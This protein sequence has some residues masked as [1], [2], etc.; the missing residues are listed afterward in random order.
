MYR[1]SAS[2]TYRA[3]CCARS[4]FLCLEGERCTRDIGRHDAARDQW[5]TFE[6]VEVLPRTGENLLAVTLLSR[7][8]GLAGSVTVEQVE[9]AVRYSSHPSKL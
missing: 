7:P 9:V 5:L 6:L 1:S 4:W 3:W 2:K 8:A